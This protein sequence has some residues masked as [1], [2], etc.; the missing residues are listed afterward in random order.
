MDSIAVGVARR[1]AERGAIA[2]PAGLSDRY[3]RLISNEA[4]LAATGSSTAAEESV[5]ARLSLATKAFRTAK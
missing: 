1:I 2:D 5:E 4:Y 3:Q